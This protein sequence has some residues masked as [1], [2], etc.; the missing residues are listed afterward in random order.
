[1]YNQEA[2]DSMKSDSSIREATE[3]LFTYKIPDG[4][5]HFLFDESFINSNLTVIAT[6]EEMI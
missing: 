2:L 3:Y 4:Q 1:M 5:S 6:Q